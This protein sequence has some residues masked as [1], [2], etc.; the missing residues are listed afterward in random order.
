MRKRHVIK[1]TLATI[2]SMAMVLGTL[3][4]VFAAPVKDEGANVIEDDLQNSDPADDLDFEEL[5]ESQNIDMAGEE[6]TIKASVS[7]DSLDEEDV[8]GDFA[9]KYIW[10]LIP[11][12]LVL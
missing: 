2:L 8:N 12:L 9:D 6:D 10:L 11:T 3:S 1:S 4:P 7:S 5:T